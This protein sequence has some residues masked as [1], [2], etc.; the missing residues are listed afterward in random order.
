MKADVKWGFDVP[1][2]ITGLLN[3]HPRAAMAFNKQE[4][5]SDIV[6]FFDSMIEED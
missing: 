2:M 4:D 3:Q 5:C 1:Y 6:S